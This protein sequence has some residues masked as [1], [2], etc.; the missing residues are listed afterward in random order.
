LDNGLGLVVVPR[1][2]SPFW[3]AL[4]GFHG[5]DIVGAPPGVVEV[6]SGSSADSV[7]APLE[8]HGI[9]T[10]HMEGVDGGY[11]RVRSSS[12][13]VGVPLD[14]LW[15]RRIRIISGWPTSAFQQQELPV[16]SREDRAP[17]NQALREFE[18]AFLPSAS[19]WPLAT[20]IAAV[21][22]AHAR[23]RM[24]AFRRPENAVLVVVGDVNPA[25]IGEQVV[26]RFGRWRGTAK[27]PASIPALARERIDLPPGQRTMV[28]HRPQASQA[29]IHIGCL[30]P[31]MRGDRAARY[32]VFANSLQMRLLQELRWKASLTYDVWAGLSTTADGGTWFSMRT[33]V[34]N[35][36]LGEALTILRREWQHMQR[37]DEELDTARWELVRSY[38]LRFRTSASTATEIYQAWNRHW[39]LAWLDGYPTA[40]AGVAARDLEP[41]EARCRENTALLII[42]D[43]ATIRRALGP[44]W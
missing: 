1:R 37:S 23:S 7:T 14:A 33:D 39:P 19:Y 20:D 18:L 12:V 24:Q 29:E 21:T 4:L 22:A 3:T 13:E 36:R 5:G 26:E 35:A 15:E 16:L 2:G 27:K 42:G 40:L 10:S 43:D 11:E 9:T 17:E 25:S 8:M 32:D 28:A 30:L 44:S 34:E 31:P 41:L 6:A 38:N